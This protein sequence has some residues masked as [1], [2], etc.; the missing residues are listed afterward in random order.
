MKKKKRKNSLITKKEYSE[1]KQAEKKLL[2]IKDL[3]LKAKE[4]FDKKSQANDEL[5]IMKKDS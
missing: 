2:E 4:E 3:L 5:I 1:L